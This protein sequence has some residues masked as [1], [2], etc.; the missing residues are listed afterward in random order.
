[1]HKIYVYSYNEHDLVNDII[2]RPGEI[3]DDKSRVF[4]GN[5]SYDLFGPY[6]LHSHPGTVN[7]SRNQCA[8]YKFYLCKKLEPIN[9]N[10]LDKCMLKELAKIDVKSTRIAYLDL[11]KK[12][13][14]IA[15]YKDFDGE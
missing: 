8:E 10:E 5:L 3:Y 15:Q 9:K 11:A 2:F 12:S 13:N 7:F 4:V 6:I 1:M 14:M